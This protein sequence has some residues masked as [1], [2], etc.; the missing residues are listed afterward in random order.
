MANRGFTYT[1]LEERSGWAHFCPATESEIDDLAIE[2]QGLKGKTARIVRGQRCRSKEGL[3]QEIASALQF[4][5]YFGD[6]WDA[7]EECLGDLGWI[8][9]DHLTLL[10]TNVDMLL[11]SGRKDLVTFLEI[12]RSVHDLEETVLERVVFQCDETKASSARKRLEG[13]L[14]ESGNE[15][16]RK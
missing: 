3:F 4:P 14:A 9:S 16:G 12:L 6:N 15:A 13:I 2:I 11:S 10:I 1:D 8:D 5:H 7:L